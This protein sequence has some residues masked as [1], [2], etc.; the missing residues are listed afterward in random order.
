MHV[1]GQFRQKRQRLRCQGIVFLAKNGREHTVEA[2]SSIW[3][4]DF[5]RATRAGFLTRSLLRCGRMI[6]RNLVRFRV[7]LAGP[8]FFLVPICGVPVSKAASIS[9][10]TTSRGKP[11]P[12]NPIAC[13][14]Y[15]YFTKP[16]THEP[17]P[18]NPIRPVSDSTRSKELKQHQ[19]RFK[20]ECYTLNLRNHMARQRGPDSPRKRASTRFLWRRVRSPKGS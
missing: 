10:L 18:R 14:P 20:F 13:N 19:L 5:S 12:L 4:S 8:G 3:S 2:T 6:I 9:S 17:Y 7:W 15:S 1:A 16:S 11:K